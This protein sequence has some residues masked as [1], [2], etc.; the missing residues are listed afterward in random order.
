MM[1]GLWSPFGYV[2]KDDQFVVMFMQYCSMFCWYDYAYLVVSWVLFT[3]D[4]T[5]KPA[6]KV[7]YLFLTNLEVK[8]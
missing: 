7:I 5:K 8:F 1:Q 2:H 3:E 4:A 6:K